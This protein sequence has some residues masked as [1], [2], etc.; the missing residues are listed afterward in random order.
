MVLRDPMCRIA[1]AQMPGQHCS[2]VTPLA[3]LIAAIL[4]QHLL[5][6]P[7]CSHATFTKHKCGPASRSHPIVLPP[8]APHH[9]PKME[10]DLMA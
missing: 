8:L 6:L 5:K 1:A 7:H 3:A 9:L 10:D 2:K 4:L